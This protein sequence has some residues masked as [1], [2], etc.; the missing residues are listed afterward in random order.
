[1]LLQVNSAC[2]HGQVFDTLK[3]WCAVCKKTVDAKTHGDKT[4]PHCMAVWPEYVGEFLAEMPEDDNDD[5]VW[6]T[7]H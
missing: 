6:E 5:F 1:M 3:R 2:D 4:C 7:L